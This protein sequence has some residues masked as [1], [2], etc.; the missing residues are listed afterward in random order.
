MV[1]N[2]R[3]DTV[4]REEKERHLWVS[5][6]HCMEKGFISLNVTQV[7]METV[8]YTIKSQKHSHSYLYE[9]T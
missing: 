9:A 2:K 4:P 5:L 6:Q 1:W 8:E 7:K 3:T